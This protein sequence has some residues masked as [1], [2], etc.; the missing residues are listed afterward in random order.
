MSDLDRRIKDALLTVVQKR[1]DDIVEVVAWD[2]N[3]SGPGCDTCGYGS[4]IEISVTCRRAD[5][6]TFYW[7]YDGGFGSLI[8]ELEGS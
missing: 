1:R 8:R 5:G 2:D 3:Y 6:S 7:D 4:G